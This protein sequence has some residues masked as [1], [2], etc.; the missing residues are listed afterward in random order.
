[1]S[2][3]YEANITFSWKQFWI[4]LIY[5]SLPPVFLSPL[6]ALIIERSP[7]KAWNVC[8]NRNLLIVSSHNNPLYFILFSW[9]VMYP[10]SWLITAGMMIVLFLDTSSL[11]AIDPL[12][13]MFAYS[14]LS[15][16]RLIIAIKEG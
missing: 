12:Q 9:L 10:S 13:M 11:G 16:R 5:E 2:P 8:Q 15:M 14:I 3:D 4:S 6:A 1:M 7:Q